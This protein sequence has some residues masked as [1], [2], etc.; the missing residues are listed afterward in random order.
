MQHGWSAPVWLPRWSPARTRPAP[1]RISPAGAISGTLTLWGYCES[2]GGVGDSFGL[3]RAVTGRLTGD[4]LELEQ[5]PCRYSARIRSGVVD[6]VSGTASCVI[7]TK[8][9]G[10]W[11]MKRRE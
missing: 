7:E 5:S 2:C 9:L 6:R 1:R 8:T 10:E 3:S 4:R 11:E